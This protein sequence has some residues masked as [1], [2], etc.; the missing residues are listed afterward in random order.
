[1]KFEATGV[2]HFNCTK[3]KA[4]TPLTK[5]D[6]PFNFVWVAENATDEGPL[7]FDTYHAEAFKWGDR[8]AYK[9]VEF[10]WYLDEY[11]FGPEEEHVMLMRFELEATKQVHGVGRSFAEFLMEDPRHF[12]PPEGLE[13]HDAADMP[14]LKFAKVK[15]YRKES[16][17]ELLMRK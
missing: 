4:K 11:A 8:H 5:R 3:G 10:T 1:M 9:P 16:I 2:T 15:H 17:I 13:C 6:E 7:L 14:A 12:A